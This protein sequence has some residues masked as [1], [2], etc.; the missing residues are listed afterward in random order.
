MIHPV[1]VLHD[2][3][4]LCSLA[5]SYIKG[6]LHFYMQKAGVTNFDWV[7]SYNYSL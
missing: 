4:T 3:C 7:A 1:G 2:I 5:V 6:I